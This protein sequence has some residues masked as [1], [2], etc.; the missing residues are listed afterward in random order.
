MAI[1]AAATATYGII[2]NVWLLLGLMTVVGIADGYGFIAGQVLISRSVAEHRQAGALG[3][4]GASE[5]LGAAIAA[6]PAAWLYGATGKGLTW[7][8]VAM[9][10]LLLLAIGAVRLRGTQPVNTSGVD[11]DWTPIDRHPSPTVD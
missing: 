1:S 8:I 9:S 6:V 4:M 5:V 2:P 10:A 7:L 3:L 11:L